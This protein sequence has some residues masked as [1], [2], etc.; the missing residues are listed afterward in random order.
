MLYYMGRNWGTS[1]EIHAVMKYKPCIGSLT[2]Q[3]TLMWIRS[4]S[5]ALTTETNTGMVT[6]YHLS[7]GAGFLDLGKS[8]L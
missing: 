5:L 4:T 8:D 1:T 2:Q 7:R 3:P 6:P